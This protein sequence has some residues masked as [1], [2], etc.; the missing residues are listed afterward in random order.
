METDSA[1]AVRQLQASQLDWPLLDD[2]VR[3]WTG[4]A[5]LK[6]GDASQ[7]A[8]LFDSIVEAPD[9]ILLAR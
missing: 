2:Y 6:Q 8:M 7:A 4:E 3:L 5:L 9:S 1:D